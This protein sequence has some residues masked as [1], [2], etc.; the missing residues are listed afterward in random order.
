V[1]LSFLHRSPSRYPGAPRCRRA[2]VA[3]P[4]ATTPPGSYPA[5]IA[6]PATQAGA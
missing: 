5:A 4:V 1:R 6:L 2:G 3:A